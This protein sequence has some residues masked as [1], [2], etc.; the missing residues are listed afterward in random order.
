MTVAFLRRVQIFLLT[1]L[2]KPVFL[3]LLSILSKTSLLDGYSFGTVV[4]WTLQRYT[5]WSVGVS[6]RQSC[7]SQWFFI[8]YYYYYKTCIA[9][10]FKHAQVGGAG[11]FH[12]ME[13]IGPNQRQRICFIQFTRWRHQAR[14]QKEFYTSWLNDSGMCCPHAADAA[15]TCLSREMK[16][17]INTKRHTDLTLQQCNYIN[18]TISRLGQLLTQTHTHTHT[19]T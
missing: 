11:C 15:D 18:M 7:S 2:L 17:V 5:H 12:I 19:H 9:H 3:S 8:Y 16:N 13:R 10:K 4:S 1:Y 6:Y 14:N